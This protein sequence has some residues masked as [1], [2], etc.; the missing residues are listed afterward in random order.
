MPSCSKKRVKFKGMHRPE[1][2]Y[3]PR[4]K[5]RGKT[6]K[7]IKGAI[8]ICPDCGMVSV[9]KRWFRGLLQKDH[10]EYK[11]ERTRCPGCEAIKKKKI[12]G[13]V[14]LRTNLARKSYYEVLGLIH[15]TEEE[16]LRDNPINRII[17]I[18]LP[19]DNIIRVTTTSQFLAKRIG[20]EFKKAYNG[21]LNI[22]FSDHDHY[23]HAIWTDDDFQGDAE[24]RGVVNT[25]I[26]SKRRR[27]SQ[28]ILEQ[29]IKQKTFSQ[30]KKKK[31]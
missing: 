2:G 9:G 21:N 26:R 18:S 24:E 7:E 5:G 28:K 20:K 14:E 3:Y 29:R 27:R 1:M 30:E 8:R 15:H 22:K 19:K 16:A 6:K 4:A 31:R 13:F 10:L 25:K 23:L 17:A 12:E 11:I